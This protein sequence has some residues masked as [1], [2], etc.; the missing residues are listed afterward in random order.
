MPDRTLD[1]KKVPVSDR[2][3]ADMMEVAES[4]AIDGWADIVVFNKTEDPAMYKMEIIDIQDEDGD[5]GNGPSHHTVDIDTILRGV[6]L[7]LDLDLPNPFDHDN[8][9]MP[10]VKMWV[11]SSIYNDDTSMFDTECANAVIQYGLFGELVY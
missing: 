4:D 11:L 2:L 7:I 3:L 9:I 6:Q 1:I 5:D 8:A 10:S